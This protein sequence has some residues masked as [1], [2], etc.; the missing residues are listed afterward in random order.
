VAVF[1]SRYKRR[2]TFQLSAPL[3]IL[4]DSVLPAGTALFEGT[5]FHLRGGAAAPGLAVID[6]NPGNA[7]FPAQ[8]I[9]QALSPDQAGSITGDG[10][11]PCIRD[12]TSSLAAAGD[13]A[14]LLS[15][16]YLQEF[17]NRTEPQSADNV[18]GD[19][20]NWTG[21]GVT[22]LGFYDPGRPPNAPGQRPLATVVTSDLDIPGNVSGGGLLVVCG[23]MRVTGTFV[24][25][26]LVLVIGSGE[27]DLR[28]VNM[29]VTGAIFLAAVSASNGSLSWGIPKITLGGN[30]QLE[31]NASA[32]RMGVKLI[33]PAQT[34]FREVTSTLD[35][36]P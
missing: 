23:R 11:P 10:S 14:L 34:G 8:Q 35:P 27:L 12:I 29:S 18:L 21:A 2:S 26:G 32:V 9:A 36:N 31:L 13:A 3:V 4:G 30:I 19:G 5:G 24:F 15:P 7:S 33:P 1:E 17:I 22:D 16:S 6:P 20:Q 28:P 25:S